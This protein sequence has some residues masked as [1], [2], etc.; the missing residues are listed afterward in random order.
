MTETK[1]PWEKA[2]VYVIDDDESLRR[3]IGRLLESTGLVYDLFD[4]AET[5]MSSCLRQADVSCAVVDIRMGKGLSGIELQKVMQESKMNIPIIFITGH[6]DV[7][8]S[9]KALKSGALHF[10]TK[11]FENDELMAAIDEALMF[12][13][14]NKKAIA[15]L[16]KAKAG[17]E[18]LT[19]R[20]R[21]VFTRVARGFINKKIAEDLQISEKTVKIHRAHMIDKMRANSTAELVRMAS[22]LVEAKILTMADIELDTRD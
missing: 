22:S 1:K 14:T 7:Q 4:S 16:E 19:K 21:Q 3:A 17:Y 11:P 13:Y 15:L 8:T 18:N 9:V 2:V 6:G 12:D 5:F 10:I 20:E